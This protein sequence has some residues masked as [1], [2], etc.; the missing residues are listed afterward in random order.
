M[1]CMG[2]ARKSPLVPQSVCRASVRESNG[3]KGKQ[4][5]YKE[6]EENVRNAVFR[7]SCEDWALAF[8]AAAPGGITI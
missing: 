6:L 1:P 2:M 4:C 3:M 7:E 8:S 5:V